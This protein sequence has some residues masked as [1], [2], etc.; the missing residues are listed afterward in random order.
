MEK[1]ALLQ[2]SQGKEMRYVYV[3]QF[4]LYLCEVPLNPHNHKTNIS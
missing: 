2:N 4:V 1:E 3:L